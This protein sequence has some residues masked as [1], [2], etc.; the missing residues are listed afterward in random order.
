MFDVER[1]PWTFPGALRQRNR[2]RITERSHVARTRAEAR[3]VP[4]DEADGAADGR[5]RRPRDELRAGVDAEFTDDGAVD[6][7][8]R[9]YPR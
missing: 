5:I 7:H 8:E 3:D 4:D 2:E 9:K 1:L 6:Q